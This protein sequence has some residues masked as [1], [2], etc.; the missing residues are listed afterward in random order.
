MTQ[1]CALR[2]FNPDA[3]EL[4]ASSDVQDDSPND[5]A[6]YKAAVSTIAADL[7][8]VLRTL[9]LGTSDV[10][11]LVD[12][13][14]SARDQLDRVIST[15]RADVGGNGTAAMM[16]SRVRPDLLLSARRGHFRAR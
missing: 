8:R 15:V 11:T 7:A 13:L 10:E 4:R 16:S 5:P 1:S 9:A 3:T 14:S 12:E 6:V 2:V